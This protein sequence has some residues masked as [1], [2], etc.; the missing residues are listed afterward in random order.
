MRFAFEACVS[1]NAE[2]KVIESR[3]LYDLLRAL[4]T[5]D[6]SDDITRA[7][8]Q[9]LVTKAKEEVAAKK[10]EEAKAKSIMAKGASLVGSGV[11]AVTT[12]SFKGMLSKAFNNQ[13]TEDQVNFSEF[14]VM[15]TDVETAKFL[16]DGN[17]ITA[18]FKIRVLKY[19]F[20]LIDENGDGVLTFDEFS[21]ASDALS[22]SKVSER[23]AMELWGIVAPGKAMDDESVINFFE[24]VTGMAE[25]QNDAVYSKKF[26][27][28]ETNVLL[29]MIV[30]LP[31]SV[32]EEQQ[33]L[34]GM[35]GIERAGMN[36]A[37]RS[38][39]H[40][41]SAE[42]RNEVM[43]MVQ[44]RQVHILTDDQQVAMHAVHRRNVL[45]GAAAGF[46]SAVFCALF[47]NFLTW[48]LHTDGVENPFH[49]V[50]REVGDSPECAQAANESVAI[51]GCIGPKDT[52]ERMDP[53]DTGIGGPD[54]HLDPLWPHC[55]WKGILPIGCVDSSTGSNE[56]CDY[57]KFG[58]CEAVTN[59]TTIATFWAV[60]VGAIIVACVFEIGTLYWYSIKN[61][62]LVADA[63]NMHLDPLN[64]DRAFV[65]LSLVRAALELGNTN[66][67]LFGIDPLK[68]T[69]EGSALMVTLFTL[70]YKAKV[71]LTGF[72]MKIAIK[73]VL[74]RGGAKYAL[75]WAAVPATAFWDGMISHLC[76]VEAKLRGTGVATSVEVF[77]EILYDLDTALEDESEVFKMQLVRA[78]GCNITK[79]RDIYPAKEILLRHIVSE[80][81]FMKLLEEK[82]SGD[83]DN[84]E[85]F[86]ATLEEL[87]GPEMKVV[88]EVLVLVTVLDGNANKR[89]RRLYEQ[90]LQVCSGTMEGKHLVVHED[91]V[92]KLAQDYRSL[93]PI[94]KEAIQMCLDDSEM[95]LP[96]SYYWNECFHWLCSLL[97]CV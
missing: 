89:E 18:A 60:L 21:Q 9:R 39:Q 91:R 7:D 65:G 1:E 56:A 67:V 12:K 87:T 66:N 26:D 85:L 38:D 92:R 74:G 93:V 57:I 37:K 53:L 84:V 82:E 95:K 77:Q 13:T 49:C 14:F 75:P 41:W 11:S 36:L 71:V 90:A 20:G 19:A 40:A 47:E 86:L 29:S 51:C 25:V 70:M 81:G 5:S 59:V 34:A 31:V 68:D 96:M 4:T 28:F 24:F 83:L 16:P 43:A 78:V 42:K 22:T 61:S 80:L 23:L 69:R 97:I 76:I 6:D 17:F 64:K 88:L 94:T 33:L 62:V 63:L 44:K 35:E 30:D 52:R 3:L 27:L 79:G 46:F 15:M 72:L 32:V 8:V 54:W 73:R 48:W 50:P 45:Q 2:E 55:D 58:G 10:A